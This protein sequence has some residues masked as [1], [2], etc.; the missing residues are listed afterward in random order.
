[1][2]MIYYLKANTEDGYDYYERL[3]LQ[4]NFPAANRYTTRPWWAVNVRGQRG[5]HSGSSA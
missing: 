4:L 1:M 5:G 2:V 3:T